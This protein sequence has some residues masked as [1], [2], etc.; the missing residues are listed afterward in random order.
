MILAELTR[1][2]AEY[3]RAALPDLA[4]H[5]QTD[6]DTVRGMLE[7]L[8]RKGRARRIGNGLACASGCGKC[9]QAQVEAWEWLG[10]PPAAHQ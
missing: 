2:L 8:E 1:Y 5:L 7:L 4:W 10:G 9:D 3:Q 6:Q